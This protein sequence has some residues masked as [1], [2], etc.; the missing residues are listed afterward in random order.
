MPP[1]QY[2]YKFCDT[3]LPHTAQPRVTKFGVII[4]YVSRGSAT[5]ISRGG[6]LAS[7]KFLGLLCIRNDNLSFVW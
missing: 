5:P 4:Q 1:S 3:Y 2:S 7:P 6:A